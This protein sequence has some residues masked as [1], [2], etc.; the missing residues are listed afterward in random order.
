[1]GDFIAKMWA[2]FKGLPPLHLILILV[3]VLVVVGVF[4][5]RDLVEI[6]KGLIT[7]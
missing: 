6:L 7:K 2:E 1:L 4:T 3:L 5:W